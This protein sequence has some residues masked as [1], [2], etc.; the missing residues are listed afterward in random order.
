MKKAPKVSWGRLALLG[1]GIPSVLSANERFSFTRTPSAADFQIPGASPVTIAVFITILTLLLLSVLI[2]AVRHERMKH[3]KMR[4]FAE[5]NFLA[6]AKKY[7]LDAGELS[8]LRRL[9]L[10]VSQSNYPAIFQSLE[11]FEEAVDQEC[12]EVRKKWGLTP[13]AENATLLMHTIRTKLGNDHVAYEQPVVST[14]NLERGQFISLSHPETDE[15]LLEQAVFSGGNELTFSVY[16]RA[17]TERKDLRQE[18]TVRIEFTRNGDGAYTAEVLVVKAT[19]SEG[20]LVLEHTAKLSRNQLRKHVRMTV[21][22]PVK[23]RVIRRAD[24]ESPPMVGKLMEETRAVDIGGGGM[25]FL[26]TQ[27]L[28]PDDV[29]SLIFTLNKR[30]FAIKAQVISVSE[31]EGKRQMNY[32][33]RVCFS[34]IDEAD[35]ES[36]VKYIFQKQREQ[37]QFLSGGKRG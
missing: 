26:S 22:I 24:R 23:C 18:K 27:S 34:D 35:V 8:E 19:P 10:R 12:Q 33:H 28:D 4:T 31:Q 1:G 7:S 25:A 6:T 29:I 20:H 3:K 36:I 17:G 32:K 13:K 30:K 14:R 15:V 16:Y 5:R 2:L 9:A 21:D 37:V 11:F